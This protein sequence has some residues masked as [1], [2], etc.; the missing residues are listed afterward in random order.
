MCICKQ[1]R[2]TGETPQAS[3]KPILEKGMASLP[4]SQNVIAGCKGSK[5]ALPAATSV[6]A[7]EAISLEHVSAILDPS[8]DTCATIRKQ[9]RLNQRR[10]QRGLCCDIKRISNPVQRPQ[11]EPTKSRT[12][13][14]LSTA[15]GTEASPA[16]AVPES[17]ARGDAIRDFLSVG[18]G[19]WDMLQEMEEEK[20]AFLGL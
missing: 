20:R 8:F 19:A 6:Q 12:R 10:Q 2:S 17:D 18:H 16:V 9:A 4:P 13:C 3:R 11:L 5:S 1:K 14:F 15:A 7:T